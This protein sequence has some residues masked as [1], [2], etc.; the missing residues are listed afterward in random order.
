VY[1]TNKAKRE[2]L[3]GESG[4]WKAS[5]M[6]MNSTEASRWI[7]QEQWFRLHFLKDINK[8]WWKSR[9]KFKNRSSHIEDNSK[10]GMK[11]LTALTTLGEYE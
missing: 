9:R 3:N 7:S 8:D 6:I 1:L 2:F 4:G 10:R 5:W 11:N